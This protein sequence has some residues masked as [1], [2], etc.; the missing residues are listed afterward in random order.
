MS[1]C[2]PRRLFA[3]YALDSAS[4]AAAGAAAAPTYLDAQ[5]LDSQESGCP[6]ASPNIWLFWLMRL[7]LLLSIL[8][9]LLLLLLLHICTAP[10]DIGG[11][12]L[13]PIT[14]LLMVRVLE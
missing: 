3:A 5:N 10:L 1:L 8:F 12:A 9:L 6:Y 7:L 14:S 4:T 2:Q 11:L 13:A